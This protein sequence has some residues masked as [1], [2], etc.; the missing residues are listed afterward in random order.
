MYYFTQATETKDF[1][2]SVLC[3]PTKPFVTPK[4]Y[5]EIIY[6]LNIIGSLIR[7]VY[8]NGN[9]LLTVVHSNISLIGNPKKIYN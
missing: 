5:T 2:C 1:R 9:P 7:Y 8:F 3:N 4:A 6:C